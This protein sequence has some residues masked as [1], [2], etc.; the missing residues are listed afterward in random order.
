ML[1][2]CYGIHQT[3]HHRGELIKDILF[4][5]NHITLNTNT[6]TH[7]LPNQTQQPTSPA[8]TTASADLHALH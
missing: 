6:P 3:E 4:N 1:T 8:I 5:S 7:L 2:Y